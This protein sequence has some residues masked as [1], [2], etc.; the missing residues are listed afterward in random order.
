MFKVRVTW[1][2]SLSHPLTIYLSVCPSVCLSLEREIIY[3]KE[4]AP[5]GIPIGIGCGDAGWAGREELQ[6]ESESHLL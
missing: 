2:T 3:F 4:L 1:S 5:I 6:F